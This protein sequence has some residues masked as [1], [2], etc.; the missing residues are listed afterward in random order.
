MFLGHIAVGLAGKH[1]APR[2]S[3]AALM[4]APLLLDGLWPIF[5]L[6]GWERVEIVPG[7]TPLTPFDFVHYPWSHSL[8][9]VLVWAALVALGYRMLMRDTAGAWWLGG[10]VVSHWFMD[11]IMHRPD[12]PLWPGGPRVGLGLWYW[13][14]PTVIVE[15]ATLL[16][17]IWFYLRVTRPRGWKGRLSLWSL[18]ATASLLYLTSLRPLPEGTTPRAIAIGALAGW[19]FVPWAW[20]IDSTR[21]TVR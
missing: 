18:V 9:M 11:L 7:I 8:A 1:Y 21:R 20:W 5:L 19:L 10:A 15:F 6:L 2:A 13:P 16:L 3:L 12:L 14:I 4:L 17:G